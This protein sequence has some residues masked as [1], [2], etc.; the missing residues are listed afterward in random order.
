MKR[1]FKPNEFSFDDSDLETPDKLMACLTRMDH[2]SINM[3]GYASQLFQVVTNQNSFDS[4]EWFDVCFEIGARPQLQEFATSLVKWHK[5][6]DVN[7]QFLPDILADSFVNTSWVKDDLTSLG[8][9]PGQLP[10]KRPEDAITIQA[11]HTNLGM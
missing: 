4:D 1:S 10:Q 8:L 3:P 5:L 9:V 7:K 6:H 2:T 11:S